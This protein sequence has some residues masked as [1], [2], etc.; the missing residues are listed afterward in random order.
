MNDITFTQTHLKA[1]L[2]FQ[3]LN[4]LIEFTQEQFILFSKYQK[5]MFEKFF[6]ATLETVNWSDK[7]NR[8]EEH[9]NRNGRIKAFMNKKTC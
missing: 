5:T 3:I 7:Y 1:R 6:V 2:F 9:W 8:R 4:F